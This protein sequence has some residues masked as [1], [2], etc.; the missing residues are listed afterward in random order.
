MK[1]IFIAFALIIVIFGIAGFS[2]YHLYQF[3]TEGL[4]LL[5]QITQD[6]KND[7]MEAAVEK[8]E[9]FRQLW[10]QAEGSLIQFVRRD[11]LEQ[12]TSISSRLPTLGEY[13]NISQFLALT[14]ELHTL[15]EDLWEDE[16]PT[17]HNII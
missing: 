13:G 17:L 11:P 2:L 15:I 3:K 12:I 10:A 9:A 4:D 8:A 6:V 16:L 1:R 5:E 7:R 14:E